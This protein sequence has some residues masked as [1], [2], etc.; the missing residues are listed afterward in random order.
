MTARMLRAVAVLAVLTGSLALLPAQQKNLGK[1]YALLVGVNTYKSSK[2]QN[3]KH[4]ENDVDQLEKALVP[5]G[6]QARTLT[7]GRGKK[8]R[9]DEPTAENV[10]KALD[11]LVKKAKKD[12]VI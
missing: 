8:D 1:K 5:A 7:T 10:R 11:E 6:F 9:K 2:L 4:A 12:D 3:L